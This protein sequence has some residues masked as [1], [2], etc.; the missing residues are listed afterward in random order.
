MPSPDAPIHGSCMCGAVRFRV[1][2]PF[3]TAGYC[4]CTRCRRRSGSMASVNG[5]VGADAF[6]LLEGA[7]EIETWTPDVGLPKSFCRRCGGQLFSGDPA[8]GGTMGIRFGA[9]DG[10]P[11]IRPR[12]R[13]WVSSSPA[14]YAIPEDGL[15]RFPE[16][17][18]I[19][20]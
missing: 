11:G 16:R 17:R 3:R 2:A 19:D 9:L 12:W 1:T 4:H 7:G 5:M 8:G 10:D 6:E 18:Q 20:V 15:P 14:W 13:Q